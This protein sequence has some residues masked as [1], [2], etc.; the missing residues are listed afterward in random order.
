MYEC[1]GVGMIGNGEGPRTTRRFASLACYG[2]GVQ[3]GCAIRYKAAVAPAGC[4]RDTT[5]FQYARIDAHTRQPERGCRT[6]N[7]RSNDGY[8]CFLRAS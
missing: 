5:R 2:V 8:V 4:R 3:P 7:A 6:C 1:F